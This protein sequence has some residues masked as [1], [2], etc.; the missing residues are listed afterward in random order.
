MAPGIDHSVIQEGILLEAFGLGRIISIRLE[1][2]FLNRRTDP[3]RTNT[4]G[5]RFYAQTALCQSTVDAM[6]PRCLATRSEVERGA[7]AEESD[8]HSEAVFL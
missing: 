7:K 3:I 2:R 4:A 5:R 6:L 8:R 1:A